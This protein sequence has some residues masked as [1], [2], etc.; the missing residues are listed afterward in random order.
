MLFNNTTCLIDKF[1]LI[2][3]SQFR[4]VIDPVNF[5]NP[6]REIEPNIE[7]LGQSTS[8]TNLSLELVPI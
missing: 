8:L 2:R 4:E 5:T 6:R 1:N 7:N 3:S